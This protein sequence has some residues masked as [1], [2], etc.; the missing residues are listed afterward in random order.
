MTSSVPEN[1][2]FRSSNNADNFGQERHHDAQKYTNT[3][4][5]P[6]SALLIVP[7][8]FDERGRNEDVFSPAFAEWQILDSR[9]LSVTKNLLWVGWLRE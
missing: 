2:V 1:D 5:S 6:R 8:L 3:T 4:L 7:N 9:I